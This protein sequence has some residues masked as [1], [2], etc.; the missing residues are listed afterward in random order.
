MTK[1][2]AEIAKEIRTGGNIPPGH[3]FNPSKPE[4]EQ[5]RKMTA[6]EEKAL[7]EGEPIAVDADADQPVSGGPNVGRER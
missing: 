7:A 6:A 5:L 1:S 4:G 3:V 2:N